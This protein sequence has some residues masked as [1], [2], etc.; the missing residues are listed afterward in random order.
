VNDVRGARSPDVTWHA[1]DLPRD[2]R[3]SAL[4]VAGATIWLTGLPASGKSAIA[5]AVEQ[6]LVHA[7]RPAY[8]IDGDNVRHG[9]SGDL[10]F[11]PAARRENVRRVAD[12]ARMFA[13]AGV[14]ALVSLVSP[15][16]ADRRLA[17]EIHA[18]HGLRFL[19]VYV[20]TPADVCAQR[21]PKGL[22]ARARAGELRN[23]TGVDAPYEP[24][25]APELVVAGAGA[26]VREGAGCVLAALQQLA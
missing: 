22:Y 23:F 5:S 18:A 19:E 4:G 15:F 7:G 9:L 8:V 2:E 10:G 20:D 12:V 26:S 16:A 3:W 17:R 14:V 13:D 24:P 21:D 11:G 6:T 1:G 25:E